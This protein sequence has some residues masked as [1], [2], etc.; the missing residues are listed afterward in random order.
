MRVPAFLAALGRDHVRWKLAEL[1]AEALMVV[2]AVLVALGVEEWREERQLRTFA[3]RA[4][5]KVDLEIGQ[6]LAEFRRFERVATHLRRGPR[7][8][9]VPPA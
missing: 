6:S 1:A 3:E 7:L 2:F 9:S 5:A 4:R 8:L